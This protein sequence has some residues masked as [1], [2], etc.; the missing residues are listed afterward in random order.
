LK[1]PAIKYAIVVSSFWCGD[2]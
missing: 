2:T 1:V